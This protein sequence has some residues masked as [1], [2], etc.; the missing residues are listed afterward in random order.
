MENK[1][2][3][4]HLGIKFWPYNDQVINNLS[5][6]GIRGGGMNKYCD[7]LINSFPSN[8]HSIIFCQRLRGQNFHEKIDSVSVYRLPAFGNRAMRQIT[9]NVFSFIF[10]IFSLRKFNVDIIHGHMQ[11]GIYFTWLLSVIFRLKSVATPYSFTTIEQNFLYNRICKHIEKHYYKRVDALIFESAENLS[12]AKQLR[13]LIFKNAVV[14]HTGI[15]I[16]KEKSHE[17]N[18]KSKLQFIY[19]GR[20][21]KIKALSNL[22]SGI[23]L[24]T[25]SEKSKINMTIAGEG[26]LMEELKGLVNKLDLT[27]T[28]L[29]PGYIDNRDY[30]L[31]SSDIF[32][33]PSHQEGLSISLL[34]AMSFGLACVVN[35][36]G[37]P[38]KDAVFEMSDNSPETIRNTIS[39]LINNPNEINALKQ[40]ARTEIEERFS[41]HYFSSQYL[42]LYNKLNIT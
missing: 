8:V 31:V 4:L 21:V 38:F 34:E 28:V 9:A 29:I 13:G 5:L 26:E 6:K 32:I 15:T 30:A 40:K 18:Y 12:K 22:I 42:G 23:S 41:I 11:P 3:V 37:V 36:F 1:I 33:L 27:D 24:L 2:T 16:P 19:V 39:Y 35:K 10:A 20:L 7:M 14:I 25:E 17:V